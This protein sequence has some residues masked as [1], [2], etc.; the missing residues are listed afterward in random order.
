MA[1]TWMV[2]EP[3]ERANEYVSRYALLPLEFAL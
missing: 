3:V 1:C 2:A